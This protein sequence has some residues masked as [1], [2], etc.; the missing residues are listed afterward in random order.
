V[1]R[2][3]LPPR[4]HHPL[5]R[6][7]QAVALRVFS[8]VLQQ[9]DHRILGHA[10]SWK[11]QYD[12]LFIRSHGRALYKQILVETSKHGGTILQRILI[13]AATAVALAAGASAQTALPL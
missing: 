1:A 12:M 6:A 3:Q 10:L 11:R 7:G 4:A 2:R 5:R 9:R 13:T 8:D